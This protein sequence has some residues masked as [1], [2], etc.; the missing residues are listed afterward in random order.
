MKH[1]AGQ[2]ANINV[3]RGCDTGTSE[4]PQLKMPVSA[5]NSGMSNQRV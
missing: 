5:K 3:A 4:N 1:N 2:A